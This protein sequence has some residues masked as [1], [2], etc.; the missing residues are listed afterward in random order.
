MRLSLTPSG[1]RLAAS[2]P[3]P[4]QQPL[5]DA[6]AAMKP[7]RRRALRAALEEI[8]RRTETD[9]VDAPFF[10]VD[11]PAPALKPARARRCVDTF[12]RYWLS[13]M[14]LGPPVRPRSHRVP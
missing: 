13:F 10:D 8:A 5:V 2:S 9:R 1:Q 12:R 14:S 3:P 7:P 11:L 4:V 6:L